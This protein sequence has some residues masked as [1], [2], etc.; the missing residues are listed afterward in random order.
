M[1]VKRPCKRRRSEGYYTVKIF[2]RLDT[3]W[4]GLGHECPGCINY[5]LV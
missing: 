2:R 1:S 5:I 4:Q 3:F